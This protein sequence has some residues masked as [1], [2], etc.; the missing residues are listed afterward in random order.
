MSADGSDRARLYAEIEDGLTRIARIANSRRARHWYPSDLCGNRLRKLLPSL[1]IL[2][3]TTGHDDG[4]AAGEDRDGESKPIH[5]HP[6]NQP[7]PKVTQR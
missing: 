1:R 5:Q 6:T 4:S 2:R 7:N 3:T